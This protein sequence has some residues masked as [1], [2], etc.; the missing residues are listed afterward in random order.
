VQHV[1]EGVSFRAHE[2]QLRQSR[3]TSEGSGATYL[4]YAAL[5]LQ[6]DCTSCCRALRTRH[7]ATSPCGRTHAQT[8][9][10]SGQHISNHC[11]VIGLDGPAPNLLLLRHF[12]VQPFASCVPRRRG[13]AQYPQVLMARQRWLRLGMRLLRLTLSKLEVQSVTAGPLPTPKLEA[14]QDGPS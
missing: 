9:E 4:R 6:V 5:P 1:D 2:L 12:H 10:P 8:G 14:M 7:Q 3:G 13:F 11:F